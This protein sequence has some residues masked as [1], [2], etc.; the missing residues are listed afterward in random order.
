[1]SFPDTL[2]RISTAERQ[3]INAILIAK[4]GRLLGWS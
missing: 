4:L 3:R 1:M 2:P